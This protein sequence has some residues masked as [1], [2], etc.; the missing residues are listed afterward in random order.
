M[1]LTMEDLD[2]LEKNGVGGLTTYEEQVALIELA[3]LA[4]TNG[5]QITQSFGDVS[6]TVIGVSFDKL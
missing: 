5:L 4:L 6:G 3:R 2:R 1:K